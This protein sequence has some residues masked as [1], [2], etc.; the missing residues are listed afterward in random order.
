M[1]RITADDILAYA[2][3]LEGQKLRT[4][5]GQ[6][7]FTFDVQGDGLVYTV[8][9]SG[10]KRTP[11][12]M[13]YL[14]RVCTHFSKSKSLKKSDYERYDAAEGTGTHN[15]SYTLAFIVKYLAS[16]VDGTV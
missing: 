8:E 2:K 12:T 5:A 10:R 14:E 13:K 7:E 16:R 11:H 9:S 6:A 15:A 4:I 1:F 3:R